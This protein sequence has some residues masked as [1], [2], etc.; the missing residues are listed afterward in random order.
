[1]SAVTK[2]G[3]QLMKM[4]HEYDM[5]IVNKDQEIYNGLW[6]R[7]QRKDKSVIDYVITGKTYFTTIKGMHTGENKEYATFKIKRK[8]S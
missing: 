7:E 3:R 5:R 2:G 8:E 6:K 4:I 1:M